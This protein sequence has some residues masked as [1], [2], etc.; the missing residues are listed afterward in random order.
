MLAMA[1]HTLGEDLQPETSGRCD[2]QRDNP[3]ENGLNHTT[4][5]F[6]TRANCK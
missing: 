4:A 3:C 6:E 2:N 1:F 5:S